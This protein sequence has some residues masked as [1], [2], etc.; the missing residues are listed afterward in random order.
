MTVQR[1]SGRADIAKLTCAGRD[2]TGPRGTLND[3]TVMKELY[4]EKPIWPL[5]E[6]REVVAEF[7]RRGAAVVSSNVYEFRDGVPQ[8]LRPQE[9]PDGGRNF[10]ALHSTSR[11]P[12]ESWEAYVTRCAAETA[13]RL[14]EIPGIAGHEDLHVDLAWVTPDELSQFALPGYV[15]Q[16]V[17]GPATTGEGPWALWNVARG[18]D[19]TRV[20]HAGPAQHGSFYGSWA[21]LLDAVPRDAVYLRLDGRAKDV[22]GLARLKKLEVL[23]VRYVN[24]AT[25]EAIRRVPTLRHLWLDTIRAEHLRPLAGLP[26]VKSLGCEDSGSLTTLSGIESLP[27]LRVLALSNLRRLETLDD[28]RGLVR[29]RGLSV[30]GSLWTTAPIESLEPLSGLRELRRLYLGNIRVRDRSL[31]PLCSLTRLRHLDVPD[32]FPLRE[33]AELAAALPRIDPEFHEPFLKV[34]PIHSQILGCKKCRRNVCRLTR[35]TPTRLF[36][37]EC[38]APAIARHIARWERER[39]RADASRAAGSRRRP[40][41]GP[42]WAREG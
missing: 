5:A 23:Q 29:L 20:R 22:A 6:C 31:R 34:R 35:G 16:H 21:G 28:L 36:C 2:A 32:A 26:R 10:P 25:L 13:R 11:N 30:G 42:P 14:R 1:G 19:G 41:C 18:R 17:A 27:K 7:E 8:L 3:A 4:A 33:F 37:P 39:A 40:P 9:R 24:Q 38:D 15:R 12:G